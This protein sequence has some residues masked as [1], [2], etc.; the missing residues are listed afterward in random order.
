[1]AEPCLYHGMERENGR[2]YPGRKPIAMEY[3]P[4]PLT[5]TAGISINSI[6]FGNLSR[7]A[8]SV[9]YAKG[10]TEDEVAD[11]VKR[12]VVDPWRDETKVTKVR[13]EST[14]KGGSLARGTH[15]HS[16][17]FPSRVRSHHGGYRNR[18]L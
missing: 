5:R 14:Y 7:V 2:Q 16:A 10:S 11:D 8:R 4:R 3:S 18:A 1:L 12:Q 9:D 13:W 17:N 15:S 6:C